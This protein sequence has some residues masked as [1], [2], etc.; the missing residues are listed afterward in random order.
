MTQPA[1][2]HETIRD[3]LYATWWYRLTSRAVLTRTQI[4]QILTTIEGAYNT[5]LNEGA[6]AHRQAA[7]ALN[8]ARRSLHAERR[9]HSVT[10]TQADQWRGVVSAFANLDP[11]VHDTAWCQRVAAEAME[12]GESPEA[13]DA[14]AHHATRLRAELHKLETETATL[15]AVANNGQERT[16]GW[17]TE[18]RTQCPVLWVLLTATDP[19]TNQEL[20]HQ[21]NLDT[22]AC[23]DILQPLARAGLAKTVGDAGVAKWVAAGSAPPPV[24]IEPVEGDAIFEAVMAAGTAAG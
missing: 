8:E 14:A 15:R 6:L 18:I 7:A 4:N 13:H 2:N 5:R 9:A 24:R 10:A 1:T 3:S 20:A 16:A 21:A 22:Q 23:L 12:H 11:A 17:L 19:L